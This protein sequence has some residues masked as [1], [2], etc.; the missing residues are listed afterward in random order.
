[1]FN[2]HLFDVVFSISS[3]DNR[4]G[5][6]R[7]VHAMEWSDKEEFVASSEVPFEVDGSEAGLLKSHG[8]LSFLKVCF[9]LNVS[10]MF[11]SSIN[12]L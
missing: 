6:S 10:I 7:W 4:A 11:S 9:S 5:N 2:L 3:P 1:M 12:C 8:P